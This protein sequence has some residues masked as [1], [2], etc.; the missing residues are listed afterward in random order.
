MKKSNEELSIII[1]LEL[2]I[3]KSKKIR[4]KPER[5]G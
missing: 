4:L 5:K 2:Q 3:I 1:E